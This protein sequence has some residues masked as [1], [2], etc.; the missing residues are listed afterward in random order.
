MQTLINVTLPYPTPVAIKSVEA[1]KS[2]KIGSS[3]YRRILVQKKSMGRKTFK[4]KMEKRL[5]GYHIEA[6]LCMQSSGDAK[7]GHDSYK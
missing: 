6:R 2:I 3:Y 5:D 1:F 4:M 7:H